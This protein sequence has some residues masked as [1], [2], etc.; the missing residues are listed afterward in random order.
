MVQMAGFYFE[1]S[2]FSLIF[3]YFFAKS[4]AQHSILSL[5]RLRLC[6][7]VNASECTV[8]TYADMGLQ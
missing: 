8:A 2:I 1:A 7:V 4:V 6:N 3:F 5:W